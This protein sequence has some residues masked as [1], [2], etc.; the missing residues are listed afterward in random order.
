MTI[1]EL[2]QKLGVLFSQA[3]WQ[4]IEFGAKD[5]FASPVEYL[6]INMYQLKQE[7]SFNIF[8]H[9]QDDGNICVEIHF[10]KSLLFVASLSNTVNVV[11][12]AWRNS[13]YYR[14]DLDAEV[15]DIIDILFK[16]N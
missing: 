14:E 3:P 13:E 8:F 11:K 2:K 4:I 15:I 16:I 7:S 5:A 9:E 12:E 6:W 10:D 1:A